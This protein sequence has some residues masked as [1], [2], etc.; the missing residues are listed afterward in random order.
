VTR[1]LAVVLML[2]LAAGA[3]HAAEWASIRPGDSVQNDVRKQFGPPTRVS[4]QKVDGYDTTQ[5]R[6][7]G[8]QA[9]RGMVRV[10]VDFGLLTA[11]GYRP[12]VVRSMLLEPRPGVFT[13]HNVLGGW[14]MPDGAEKEGGVDVFKY[15]TGLFVYFDK[16]GWLAE[17]MYFVFMAPQAAPA[18]K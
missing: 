8:E 7:E 16:A 1:I 18:K 6:Y 4:S 12:E 5:W 14:G 15:R 17:K 3:A 2:G 13:R 11:A 10:T 9:P